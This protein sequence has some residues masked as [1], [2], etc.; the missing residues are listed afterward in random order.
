MGKYL[1]KMKTQQFNLPKSVISTVIFRQTGIDIPPDQ[2]DFVSAHNIATAVISF[3]S[4]LIDRDKF[5]RVII[6]NINNLLEREGH[7]LFYVPQ[8]APKKYTRIKLSLNYN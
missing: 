6:F 7:K 5:D 8:L 2:I 4:G 3:D 1:Y